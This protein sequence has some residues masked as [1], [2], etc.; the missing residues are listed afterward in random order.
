MGWNLE[1]RNPNSKVTGIK[2]CQVSLARD[3]Q[4]KILRRLGKMRRLENTK[5]ICR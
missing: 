3:V 1:R 4:R 2:T 5:C